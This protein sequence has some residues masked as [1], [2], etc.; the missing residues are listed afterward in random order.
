MQSSIEAAAGRGGNPVQP[1]R[2]DEGA[3]KAG[4]V[5]LNVAFNVAFNVGVKG[6]RGLRLRDLGRGGFGFFCGGDGIAWLLAR[7]LR[8]LAAPLRAVYLCGHGRGRGLR[9]GWGRG[10]GR[11]SGLRWLRSWKEP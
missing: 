2:D 3:G 7:G 11:E 5:P 1:F 8:L 4:V 6:R 10:D 9:P